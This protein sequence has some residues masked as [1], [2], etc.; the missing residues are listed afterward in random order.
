M[1]YLFIGRRPINDTMETVKAQDRGPGT[2][3]PRSTTLPVPAQLD[4][5]RTAIDQRLSELEAVLADPS[6]GESLESLIVDLARMATSEAQQAAAH[7]CAVMKQQ[8]EA[9]LADA[10]AEGRAAVDREHA[11]TT[12]LRKALDQARQRQ[13]QLEDQAQADLKALRQER[14]SVLAGERAAKAEAQQETARLERTL[15][16][17][18]R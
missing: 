7:A 17:V 12:E 5:L 1:S 13:T 3:D 14:D 10:R 6:R 11:A 16:E 9:A 18:S 15:E 2:L 4:A 8:S